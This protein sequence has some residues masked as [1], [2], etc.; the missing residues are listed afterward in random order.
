[1]TVNDTGELHLVCPFFA[2]Y[3]KISVLLETVGIYGVSSASIGPCDVRYLPSP[4]KIGPKSQSYFIS[5]VRTENTKFRA[6]IMSP[7]LRFHV[8]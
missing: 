8:L 5:R 1:M 7:V 4:I 2:I 6:Q 3:G